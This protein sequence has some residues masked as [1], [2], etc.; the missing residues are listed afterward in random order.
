[1]V[2]DRKKLSNV[3]VPLLYNLVE[4]LVKEA[5]LQAEFASFTSDAYVPGMLFSYLNPT[6]SLSCSWSSIRQRKFTAL[7][8]HFIHD[9]TLHSYTLGVLPT[10][11][12][13]T[14]QNI[15]KFLRGHLDNMLPSDCVIVSGITDNGANYVG[16]FCDLN[17]TVLVLDML[18][19]QVKT[20][21]RWC[22]GHCRQ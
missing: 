16:M 4:G 14:I 3:Y 8:I 2:P 19:A 13:H 15:E 17:W 12:A 22:R 1:V 7:T 6:I 20:S 9:W 18:F 21:F 5:V 11:E 10:P